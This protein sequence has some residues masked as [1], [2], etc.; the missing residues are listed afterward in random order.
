MGKK[1]NVRWHVLAFLFLISVTTYVDRV[2]V[3]V[4]AAPMRRELGLTRVELGA[5][6][7]A[8][9]LGYALFQI[10]GGWLGDRFGHKR[11]L[12]FA[13]VWWSVFTVLTGWVGT[14]G[15][16]TA[17]GL[18]PAFAVVRFLIGVGEAAAYPCALGLMRRWFPASERGR[19]TGIIFGGIGV[20]STITPPLVAWLMVNVGWESAFYASGLAGIALACVFGLFATERPEDHP[21]VSPRELAIIRDGDDLVPTSGAS[22]T[23]WAGILR[24]RQVWLLAAIS[25]L[26]GYVIYIF[27]FWFYL[28]LVDVRGFTLLR[29]SLF[30][31]LPFLAMTVGALVGGSLC[32][33]WA[34]RMGAARARR[35]VATIGLVPATLFLY[36]GA[37]AE[38]AYVA[39]AAL[40]LAAGLLALAPSA[41]WATAIEID[42]SRTATVM[43]VIQT[44]T[45]LG[46]AL[47][48]ILTPWIAARYGWATALSV[49]AAACLSAALL[50]R[51]IGEDE[52]HTVRDPRADSGLDPSGTR[53]AV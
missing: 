23:T 52:E 37:S 6:F 38:H 45:N 8:F 43:G 15:L 29:G 26:G 44:G 50:W 31:A 20:G 16:V 25:V 41:A 36:L 49:G 30:A 46:G 1:T 47:S 14:S 39:I 48:P 34:P 9:V 7:S 10:P 13:L 18:V 42:P 12:V 3:A 32:D 2:N 35:T 4:A 17:L 51:F 24:K 53:P 19:A 11:I 33:R 40:S 27:F 21:R 5:I 22:G 28:Y